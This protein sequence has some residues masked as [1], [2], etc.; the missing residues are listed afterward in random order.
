MWNG[1]PEH[2][3]GYLAGFLDGEGCFYAETTKY[4]KTTIT[5]TNS[6]HATIL[7]LQEVFGGKVRY[8]RKQKIHHKQLLT[9]T[10]RYG[11]AVKVCEKLAPYL[12]EK[13]EQALLIIAIQQT[14]YHGKHTLPEETVKERIRLAMR[15]KELKHGKI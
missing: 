8:D 11:D 5:C 13:A 15:L 10:V 12:K 7:R 3:K 9:W 2:E 1:L 6:Y 4:G 14:K